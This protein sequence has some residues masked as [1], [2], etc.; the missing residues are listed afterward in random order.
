MKVPTGAIDCDIHPSVPDTK[1]LLPYMSEYWSNQFTNRHLDRKPFILQSYPPNSPLSCRPDWRVQGSLPGAD[2]DSLRRHALDAFKTKL[3]ICNVL[4]GGIVLFNDDMA[5]ALCSAVNDWV[6]EKLL[7]RDPRLRAS[8]LVPMQN[9]EL[10]KAEIERAAS[11]RRFV[12]VLALVM[13]DGLLGR[14]QYWPIYE[15][16]AKH[17]LPICI[18]AGSLYRHPQTYSGWPSYQAEAYV[19]YG[20]GFE[21]TVVSLVTEGVFQKFP[22]LK[23]VCAESGVTWLPTLFWRLNKEWRGVRAEVPWINRP[24]AEIIRQHFRF[25]TQPF[26]IAPN[27]P[28]KLLRTLDHIGTD[29]I[30]LF[31]TD[32]PHWHF[33]GEDVLPDGLSEE[34]IEKLMSVNVLETYPR[35]RERSAHSVS[36]SPPQVS[37]V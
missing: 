2:L 19:A 25:T 1:Q 28:E 36:R 23:V 7:N 16:A 37:S 4:H 29:E 34:L 5:A 14:R 20:A 27:E 21:N 17:D 35:L 18:H 12:Q 33:D 11:D 3:A 30:F 31:S 24:P 8:I 9:P 15:V 22:S 32:Y 26:D 13:G 10:A 6:V